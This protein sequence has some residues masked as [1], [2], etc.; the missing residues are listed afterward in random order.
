M[1]V[2]LK[3]HDLSVLGLHMAHCNIKE[4]ITLPNS[5]GAK[6]PEALVFIVDIEK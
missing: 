4:S 5:Y 1:L 2:V 3:C 6:C